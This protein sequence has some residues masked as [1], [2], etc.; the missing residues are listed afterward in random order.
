MKI[1]SSI[2]ELIGN[3]PLLSLTGFCRARGIDA[4]LFGKLECMNPAGSVK[5]RVGLSMILDAE[6]SGRLRPGGTVI[7][8]TSG[9]TGIGLAAVA[10]PLGYRVIITMPDTM[11]VER[12][13]VLAAYGAELVLTDGSEG[14]AGAIRR[15]EELVRELP[16]AILAGQFENPANANAHYETTG[17]EIYRD[18]DGQ[19]D[20][21]IAGV[22]T[23]GTLTGVARYL[24]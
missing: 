7:E 8:P 24:K 13:R 1:Y 3:T 11:S 17:P 20:I 18:T 9:N 16:D 12:R 15:A 10:V 19:V 23:G 4:E 2:S 5:D 22:G 6:A 21:F 14:M